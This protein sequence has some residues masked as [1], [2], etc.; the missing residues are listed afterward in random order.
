MRRRTARFLTAYRYA[1]EPTLDDRDRVAA[2]R[3]VRADSLARLVESVGRN[4][5]TEGPAC[6]CGVTAPCPTR[7][8]LDQYE[9]KR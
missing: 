5:V 9:E 7:R 8:T 6:S 2:M 3:D 4:H 1:D